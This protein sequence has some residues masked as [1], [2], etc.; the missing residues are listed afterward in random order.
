MILAGLEGTQMKDNRMG[1][2]I[3]RSRDGSNLITASEIASFAYCPEQWRLEHGLEL[4]PANRAA[5]NA[6]I[7]HHWRKANA[8]RAAAACLGSGRVLIV[9]INS[10]NVTSVAVPFPSGRSGRLRTSLTHANSRRDCA[11]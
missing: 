6:G 1:A 7:R 10:S 11:W 3:K 2:Q 5:L 4:L 8:E 9:I